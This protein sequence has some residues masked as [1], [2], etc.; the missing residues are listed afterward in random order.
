VGTNHPLHLSQVAQNSAMRSHGHLGALPPDLPLP[1][2]TK[3][4]LHSFSA[5]LTSLI[6]E[7]GN[8]LP[9]STPKR[10]YSI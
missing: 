5:G 6:F 8:K 1:I 3:M 2:H 10:Y 4:E 7:V 9:M